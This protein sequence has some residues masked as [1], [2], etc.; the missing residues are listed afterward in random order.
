MKHSKMSATEET[1][2]KYE[3]PA[4]Y[5][6]KA[7]VEMTTIEIPKNTYGID[8]NVEFNNVAVYYSAGFTKKVIA[9]AHIGKFRPTHKYGVVPNKPSHDGVPRFNCYVGDYVID[10]A[11]VIIKDND[12]YSGFDFMARCAGF[13]E[14]A[15]YGIT[16]VSKDNLNTFMP[17]VIDSGRD[18]YGWYGFFEN[19]DLAKKAFEKAKASKIA[20][21]KH[22][23][24]IIGNFTID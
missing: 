8:I 1:D 21:Y 16:E 20:E 5:F 7:G 17:Y 6:K 19:I 22:K 13:D 23:I 2:F 9:K 12:E 24:E 11:Q 4:D 18:I 15:N 10:V 14:Y 3:S